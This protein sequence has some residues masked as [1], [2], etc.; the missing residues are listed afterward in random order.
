MSKK[1][2][3]IQDDLDCR[4][5]MQYILEEEGFKVMYPESEEVLE[6]V[7][8]YDLIIID[9]FSEGRTGIEICKKLKTNDFTCD[10]PIVLTS[11]TN[12]LKSL[13]QYCKADSYLVKPFD[14]NYFTQLIK[15]VLSRQLCLVL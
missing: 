12:N 14:I 15:T 10:K 6:N 3:L 4:E 7:I 13:A 5:I 8:E 11:V 2:M 9:E 1:V